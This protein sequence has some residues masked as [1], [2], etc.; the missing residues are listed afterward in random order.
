M[1][2]ASNPGCADVAE[3]PE[4]CDRETSEEGQRQIDN[5]REDAIRQLD[6]LKVALNIGTKDQIERVR[7]EV[8]AELKST[9]KEGFTMNLDSEENPQP[10]IIEIDPEV[11]S[12]FHEPVKYILLRSGNDDYYKS[13]NFNKG[14][15]HFVPLARVTVKDENGELQRDNMPIGVVAQLA[16][17]EGEKFASSAFLVDSAEFKHGSVHTLPYLAQVGGIYVQSDTEASVYTDSQKS[18]Y[19]GGKSAH[20]SKGP[21]FDPEAKC[22]VY[23]SIP[24][25][26]VFPDICHLQC[27]AEVAS[28]DAEVS[29]IETAEQDLLAYYE[30]QKQNSSICL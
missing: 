5:I 18:Y 4:T 30:C 26:A 28:I 25:S 20:I 11:A 21:T 1:L 23:D 8:I 10:S 19:E 24:G 22:S 12:L 3:T 6:R 29:L 13:E 17:F 7:K 14:H 16:E 9:L 15:M 27:R 2:I